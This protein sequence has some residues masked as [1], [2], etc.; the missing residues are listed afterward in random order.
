MPPCIKQVSW[1]GEGGHGPVCGFEISMIAKLLMT[2]H[3][4]S[5]SE[6]TAEER[7]NP[8]NAIILCKLHNGLFDS[9]FISLTDKYEV[10]LS[11]NFDFINQ[12][13]A[14]DMSFMCPQQDSPA[15]IFLTEH[16]KK[17]NLA[18]SQRRFF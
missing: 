15:A 6:S 17:N 12:G 10:I 14:T 13:I 9:G 18:I 1:A 11:T 4:K 8:Q 16:R 7:S 3:I 5:W 2:T